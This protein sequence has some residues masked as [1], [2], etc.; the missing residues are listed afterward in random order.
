[1]RKTKI[2]CTIGPASSSPEGLAA[3]AKAGM[4]VARLNFSHGSYEEH[5]NKITAI[6]RISSETGR[7]I[8]I[9]QD[10]SGPK[11]RLGV[12]TQD[13]LVLQPGQK[14]VF[15]SRDVPGD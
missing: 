15:T 6:R 8:G 4:D 1:M 5:G 13:P 3:L 14:F 2:V 12:V 7:L 10:L 11:I 9:L